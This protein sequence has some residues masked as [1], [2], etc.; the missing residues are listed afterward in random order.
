MHSSTPP[1]PTPRPV[2]IEYCVVCGHLARAL[3]LAEDILLVHP[4]RVSSMT[5]LPS[6]GGVYEVRYGERL[7]HS[8]LASGIFP[9]DEAIVD[10]I[11]ES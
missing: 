4:E 1:P 9:N 8:R 3:S 11:G 5:L 2:S 10:L 7:L 6:S